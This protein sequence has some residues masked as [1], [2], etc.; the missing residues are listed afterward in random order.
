MHIAFG[1][2][3]SERA[4][5]SAAAL[6][7]TTGLAG[8]LAS[9]G[10]H[11]SKHSTPQAQLFGTS[12]MAEDTPR[13]QGNDRI[14]AGRRAQARG[15]RDA[16]DAA[17]RSAWH[18]PGARTEAAEA[19]SELARTPGTSLR[20]DEA[21]IGRVQRLLGA[22]FGRFDTPH[23]VIVSDCSPEWTAARG[24]M[25]ERARSQFYRV[26]GRLSVPVYPHERK[27]LCV[28][29]NDHAKY[30]AFART[31]D[32]LEARWVAGYYATLSNRIV[33]YNDASSPIYEAA[34]GRLQ[35]Y[36]LQMRETR[37]RAEEAGR[38]QHDDL[39]RRL[40]A[41]ADDLDKQIKRERDRL[42]ERAAAS[43][44]AKTIH[45]AVHLLAFNSGLQLPDR[46]YP[47]WLSEGLASSFE[48][49][50]PENAFGPDRPWITGTRKERFEELR[51]EGR[52]VPLTKLVRVGEVPRWDGETADAM[53]SQGFAL[54]SMLYQQDPQA[55]GRY[56]QSLTDEPPGRIDPD[57]QVDLFGRAFGDIASVEGRL[58]RGR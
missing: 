1:Y 36:E 57:R 41:S 51:R 35:T 25:L 23:F 55:M 34:R 54:F 7:L 14:A 46:D 17:Y 16:A 5:R 50:R 27:L 29:F 30:Q 53:Y 2:L 15:D 6:I 40:H 11:E 42:G 56:I 31:Y 8:L 19:L 52:L 24:A 10:T 26:S 20:T 12:A 47:F 45:E 39:A 58:F 48:T 43:A 44:T 13:A 37:D 22:S 38:Q 4:R 9:L 33:F 49:D 21:A 18:D 32:G 3:G 28:L